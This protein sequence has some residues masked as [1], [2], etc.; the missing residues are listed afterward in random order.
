L[1]RD[2]SRAVISGFETPLDTR[3]ENDAPEAKH[4]IRF[5]LL[6]PLVYYSGFLARTI[7]VPT[8]FITDLA[9]IPRALYIA[10]PPIGAYDKAAVVHDFLYQHPD[11]RH[12]PVPA[13]RFPGDLGPIGAIH[14][15]LY[16]GGKPLERGEADTVLRE[17]M[18]SLRVEAWKR[19]A[20][21]EGVRLGGWVPWGHYRKAS[22]GIAAV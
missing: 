9:S 21:H 5:V 16:G 12:V 8:G 6:A 7:I 1:D 17:A 18:E 2:E 3:D 10:L 20:I 4:G 22:A 19:F 11:V 14:T 13:S 15:N